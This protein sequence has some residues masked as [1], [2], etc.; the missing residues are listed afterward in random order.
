LLKVRVEGQAEWYMPVIL[1][2]RRLRQEDL[3]FKASLGYMDLV[4]KKMGR[5]FLLKKLNISLKSF[6]KKIKLLLCF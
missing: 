5:S 6:K 1:A 2:L 3:E 4:L